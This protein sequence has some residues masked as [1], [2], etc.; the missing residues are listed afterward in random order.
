MC[1]RSHLVPHRVGGFSAARGVLRV[2]FSF[3]VKVELAMHPLHRSFLV[4]GSAGANSS[5]WVKVK[6]ACRLRLCGRHFQLSVRSRVRELHPRHRL[7]AHSSTSALRA[8]SSAVRLGS[9]LELRWRHRSSLVCGSVSSASGPSLCSRA[10]SSSLVISRP[11]TSALSDRNPNGS[12]GGHRDQRRPGEEAR[13]ASS[14]LPADS[15]MASV[16]V[17]P[18]ISTHPIRLRPRWV[19]PSRWEAGL[20]LR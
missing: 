6:I 20:R 8:P 1:N 17:C 12:S 5:F 3:W 19:D 2:I 13:A 15:P 4:F 10:S 9:I 14:S 18:R 16:T 11:S 7:F